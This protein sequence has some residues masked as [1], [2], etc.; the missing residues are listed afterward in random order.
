M[1]SKIDEMIDEAFAAKHAA[2]ELKL[3]RDHP[4]YVEKLPEPTERE[5]LTEIRDLLQKI[6]KE[7]TSPVPFIEPT[8]TYNLTDTGICNCWPKPPA[9][10]G[11]WYCPQHGHQSGMG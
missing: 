8:A 10:T 9:T 5:L 2:G 7:V 3:G 11:G 6:L 4:D 1:M